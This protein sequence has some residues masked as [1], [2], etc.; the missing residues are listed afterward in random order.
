MTRS[1]L[2]S[3][4]FMGTVLSGDSSCCFR[5]RPTD[6]SLLA[7]PERYHMNTIP[8]NGIF[9]WVFSREASPQ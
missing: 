5:A 3:S 2:Q 4:V 6:E 1:N 8:R 7:C 9:A